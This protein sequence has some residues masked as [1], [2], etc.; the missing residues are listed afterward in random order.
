[1]R[2]TLVDDIVDLAE[3]VPLG[4]PYEESYREV[5]APIRAYDETAASCR[6]G[7]ASPPSPGLVGSILSASLKRLK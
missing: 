1:M 7:A 2:S 3:N 4:K 5:P 6:T